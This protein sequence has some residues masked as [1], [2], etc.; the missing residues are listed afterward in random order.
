MIN[1]GEDYIFNQ[2]DSVVIIPFSDQN[3]ATKLKIM[4]DN[5][6]KMEIKEQFEAQ[7]VELKNEIKLG[8]YF[9]IASF[10]IMIALYIT[11]HNKLANMISSANQMKFEIKE[12]SNYLKGDR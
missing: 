3:K 1:S 12:N 2:E 9:L 4:R 5:K 8:F 10:S 6:V 7:I 11:N